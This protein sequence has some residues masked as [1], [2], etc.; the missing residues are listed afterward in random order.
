MCSSRRHRVSYD[1]CPDSVTAG[2]GHCSASLGCVIVGSSLGGD[3]QK[4]LGFVDPGPLPATPAG[5]HVYPACPA[6]SRQHIFIT[7]PPLRMSGRTPSLVDG[8][9][10]QVW[11]PHWGVPGECTQTHRLVSEDPGVSDPYRH[12]AAFKLL[13]TNETTQRRRTRD[14]RLSQAFRSPC[15]SVWHQGLAPR[16]LSKAR[17]NCHGP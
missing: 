9:G 17:G 2:A 3:R 1:K 7:R 5:G 4:P 10:L 14:T 6:S 8:T 16:G 11:V 13:E 15:A 12:I